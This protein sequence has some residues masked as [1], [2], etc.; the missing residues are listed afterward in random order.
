MRTSIEVY[1]RIRWD[2]AYRG[3]ADFVIGFEDR[4]DGIIEN[5]FNEFDTSNIPFHRI[6]YFKFKGTIV[7]DR[8]T[9]ID[10][11]FTHRKKKDH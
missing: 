8:V 4:F 1:N 3:G 10:I 11:L 2:K 9:R 5:A 7:Y 6:R